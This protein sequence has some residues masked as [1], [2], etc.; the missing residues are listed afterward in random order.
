ML[1]TCYG[2]KL[3]I[4]KNLQ[5]NLQ[6]LKMFVNNSDITVY[7]QNCKNYNFVYLPK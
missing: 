2:K 6:Y 7:I 1:L 4:K 3:E 5:Y